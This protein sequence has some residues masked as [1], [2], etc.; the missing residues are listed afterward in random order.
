MTR[1]EQI[2]MDPCAQGICISI[3]VSGHRL[4]NRAGFGAERRKLKRNVR[5]VGGLKWL[6]AHC[7]YTEAESQ[8][9]HD[10]EWYDALR[11]KYQETYPPSVYDK[12]KLD[13]NAE[14]RAIEGS[15][16]R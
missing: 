8:E 4:P 6:Y 1:T 10:K 13:W 16:L 14:R 2:T 12:I 5:E 3:G 9:T 11:A 7:H 15:W